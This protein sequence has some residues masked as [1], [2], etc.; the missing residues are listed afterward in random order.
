MKEIRINA[1]AG[2]GAITTAVLL[3]KAIFARGEYAY[4]FPYFGAARMGAP[5][6]SFVRTD[7]KPI[8]LRSQ[9]YY[10]DYVLVIDPTLM[11]DFDI[12][13]GMKK[14]GSAIINVTRTTKVPKPPEGIKAFSL[15]AT[16]IANEI[17]KRPFGNTVLLGAFAAASGIIDIKDLNKV[18]E[19]R[20]AGEMGVLNQKAAQAGFDY[21]KEKIK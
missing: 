12:F 16:D 2:Q 21:I 11:N 20:F 13:E 7:N 19:E 3:G 1:R 10:P 4:A 15:P 9:V 18:I 8:R 5:M 14:G 6:N 17:I